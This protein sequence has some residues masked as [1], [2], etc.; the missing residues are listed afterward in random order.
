MAL[1]LAAGRWQVEQVWRAAGLGQV[2]YLQQQPLLWGHGVPQA[3]GGLRGRPQP[4][5][6]PG[7]GAQRHHRLDEVAPEQRRL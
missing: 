1:W 5:P 4:G 6:Q 3:P 2:L 7:E